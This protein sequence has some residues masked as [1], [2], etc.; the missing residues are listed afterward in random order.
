MYSGGVCFDGG[1]VC[2]CVLIGEGVCSDRKGACSAGKVC[3]LRG[4]CAFCGASLRHEGDG[5]V[6]VMMGKCVL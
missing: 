5:K 3:V 1:S 4:M 6:C 2:V